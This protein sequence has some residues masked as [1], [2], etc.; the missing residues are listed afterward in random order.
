MPGKRPKPE[1]IVSKLRQVE[2]LQGQGM[3]IADAVRQIGVTQQTYYLYGRLS[4][5]KSISN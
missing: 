3:P 4:R 5:C 2:V 1:E